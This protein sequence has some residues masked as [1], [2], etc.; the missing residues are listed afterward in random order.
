MQFGMPTLVE[1]K[2]LE[3]CAALCN[4]LKLSFIELN[5]NLPQYQSDNIEVSRYLD[6]AKRYGVYYTIHLDEN[7]NVCDF[8]RQVADAYLNTALQTIEL[9]KTL[10]IPII[11]MHMANGVYFTLP[12]KKI[13]LFDEYIDTYLKSLEF[14]RYECEK[15]IAGSG[16][17]IC[18]ENSDGYRY[19]SQKGL[20]LLLESGAFALT[21][22]IGHNHSIGGGDEEII[23][24][25]E[26][27]LCHMH[28]HDA[29]G[30]KNHLVL[31]KGEIDLNKYF[32]L[33]E[34]HDCRAVLETKTVEGLK[35]SVE[36]INAYQINQRLH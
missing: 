10:G 20:E 18:I 12:D 15:T 3:D 33:A 13:Y 36:Y 25:R 27:R 14:F 35:R 16:I 5:M 29:S 24:R 4:E 28:F 6:I 26:D 22:D 8:N 11:N 9:A 21:F 7:F 32:K 30:S 1:T 2:S 19:F 31:G 34:R 23:M 17:K